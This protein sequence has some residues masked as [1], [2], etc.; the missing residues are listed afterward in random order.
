MEEHLLKLHLRKL[1]TNITNTLMKR[2]LLNSLRNI[3]L[4]MYQ[5]SLSE[6]YN[7]QLNNDSY[8]LRKDF[9]LHL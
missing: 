3:I 5:R 6:T 8:A 2:F 9:I 4:L 7:K 1:V